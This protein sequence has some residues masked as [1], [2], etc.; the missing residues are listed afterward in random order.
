MH[1]YSYSVG[2]PGTWRGTKVRKLL[3]YLMMAL[4]SVEV[5]N[6]AMTLRCNSHLVKEHHSDRM[7][8]SL[9]GAVID[10]HF[11]RLHNE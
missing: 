8:C 5:V 10:R 2:V 3:A 4:M 1:C 11:F 7:F 9:A 6:L